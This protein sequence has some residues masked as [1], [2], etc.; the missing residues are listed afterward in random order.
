MSQNHR[1]P[2]AKLGDLG[3][4]LGDLKSTLI[5]AEAAAAEVR[6]QEE[7]EEK[8]RTPTQP[9][10]PVQQPTGPKL[11]LTAAALARLNTPL[12]GKTQ[13]GAVAGPPPTARPARPTPAQKPKPSLPDDPAK[14]GKAAADRV[15]ALVRDSTPSVEERPHS[16]SRK[17]KS[18]IDRAVAAGA[19]ILRDRPEPD[20]DGY[21][22]GFDFGTSSLKVAYRQP[23][24]A[25]DP[26]AVITVPV[27]LRSA[28]HPGLWQSVIWYD[29]GNGDFSLYPLDG[30]IAL[31]GFK[32]GLI[33]GQGSKP[34]PQ[35]PQV[36]RAEAA[37][38]FLALQ[39]SYMV[40]AYALEKPLYPVGADHFVLINIGIPVAVRDN[41]NAFTEYSR[42]VAAAYAL[43]P[44]ATSLNL[45]ALKAEQ[46]HA[47]STLPPFLQLVPELTAAIAGYAADPMVQLGA[48]ILIDVGASTLD[49]VSF[50]LQAQLRA[51]VFTAGVDLFGAAA[52]EVARSAGVDDPTFTRACDY[53]FEDV[54]G[55]ARADTRAPS[56][57]KPG[58][59]RMPVQLVITG[60]GCDT[61]VHSRYINLLPKDQVLGAIPL[62]RPAPPSK[63]LREKGDQ[64]RL[65][66]AYGLTRDVTELHELRLPSQIDDI[67]PLPVQTYQMID[68]DMV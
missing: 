3:S 23:Y 11:R 48:H 33:A 39:F 52:L 57:F 67:P 68:K 32:T 20:E 45:Q 59:R 58:R 19:V 1:F 51:S 15:R 60:G 49:I 56:L 35:A 4:L 63:I 42:L 13:E 24:V 37:T 18:N 44:S 38:A 64:S 50:N 26:V 16:I 14:V 47:P 40:G 41:K 55:K 65:L 9:A 7:E 2:K 54:Y 17:S 21:I 12:P 30:G 34:M 25:D 27:E 36:T 62:K 8:R 10:R 53:L 43:A 46:A 28:K 66:L 22:I 6:R 31:D 29:P 61:D 5:R